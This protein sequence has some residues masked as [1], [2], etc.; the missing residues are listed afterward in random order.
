MHPIHVAA[1]AAL[2]VSCGFAV[3]CARS[4]DHGEASS[5]KPVPVKVRTV[6]PSSDATLARFSG[7]LEPAVSVKM[8]FRVNGYVEAIGE[9]KDA[10]GKVR[11]ADKGDFVK[12]GT[13]LARVRAAD[14]SQK[15][16]TARAT[17]EQARSDQKLASAELSRAQ[18]LFDSKAI[19]KAEF[20]GMVAKAEWSSANLKGALAREGE[21]SVALEDTVL[22]APMDGVILSRDVEIGSLVA[23]GQLAVTVADTRTVRAAFGVPQ[24]LVEKLQVGSRVQVFLGVEGDSAAQALDAKVSRIAPAADSRGRVFSVE[25]ELPNPAGVLRPGSVVSVHVLDATLSEASVAVPLSAVVRT[26]GDARGF[27]VFVLEGDGA[28]AKASL[29]TIKLGDV[30]GNSVTV[31][32]GLR[33]GQ[34]V[35]TVGA[36]LLRDGSEAVVIP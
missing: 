32:D 2:V 20:D 22:R 29:R 9:V 1:R 8:A 16:A 31:S 25:A 21:A 12:K 5:R 33:L 10:N 7:T 27:S 28:R 35:V 14:Y 30:L 34:R 4:S 13:M 11:F 6:E 18:R 24:A 26:P 36:A 23:P 3:A 19:S 15:V 17:V